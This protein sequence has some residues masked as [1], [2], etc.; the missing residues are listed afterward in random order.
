MTDLYSQSASVKNLSD[1]HRVL[2]GIAFAVLGIFLF[3]LTEVFAK[4][5]GNQG[6]SA[7]QL[8]FLRNAFAVVPTMLMVWKLNKF[9]N[10]KLK[11]PSTY[12]IRAML[13]AGSLWCFFY[14]LPRMLLADVA[15]LSFAAPIF[16]TML[17]PILLSEPSNARRWVCVVIGFVGVLVI[18]QP[19]ANIFNDATSLL[20]L[21]AALGGSLS[22][23]LTRHM[24]RTEPFAA[25]LFYVSIFTLA[26][27]AL[28]LPFDTWHGDIPLV[29]FIM[30]SFL[31][32]V[33]GAAGICI[34]ISYRMAPAAVIAPFDYLAIIYALTLG[35]F[36]FGEWPGDWTLLGSA[37]V[38]G[39]GLYIIHEQS[40]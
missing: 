37:M 14:A 12:I 6:Y 24:G 19:T 23:I 3:S 11:N 26:F 21:L 13:G 33:S 8:V 29:D 36:I 9:S 35:Y 22:V 17:A 18:V 28:L 40:A 1:K 31:G 25:M 5:L 38:I 16:T 30:F 32:L 39:C 10:L 15:A 34:V 20:I 4:Q 27:S 7:L 2:V